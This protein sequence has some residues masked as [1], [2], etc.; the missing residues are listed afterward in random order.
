MNA[1]HVS[2]VLLSMFVLCMAACSKG[3]KQGSQTAASGSEG[4]PSPPNPFKVTVERADAQ[5]K[6]LAYITPPDSDVSPDDLKHLGDSPMR[7]NGDSLPMI[8]IVN[9]HTFLAREVSASDGKSQLI[10]VTFAVANPTPGA[11]SF[12]LS[13]VTLVIGS[14]KSNE[15]VAAG[16]GHQMCGLFGKSREMLRDLVVDVGPKQSM[17]LSLAFPLPAEAANTGE[18]MVGNSAPGPFEIRN[19]GSSRNQ[20]QK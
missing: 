2:L 19:G 17:R 3:Q 4:K 15:F 16:Y 7:G 8:S 13:D 20:G 5:V 11:R 9:N 18:L 12:K 6:F 14:Y 10:R 1:K